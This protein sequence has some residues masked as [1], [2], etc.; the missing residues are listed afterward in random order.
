MCNALEKSH[1]IYHI[2]IRRNGHLSYFHCGIRVRFQLIFLSLIFWVYFVFFLNIL[3]SQLQNVSVN[4]L[5]CLL[6]ALLSIYSQIYFLQCTFI[7]SDK[8]LAA[9]SLLYEHTKRIGWFFSNKYFEQAKI[10][11]KHLSWGKNGFVHCCNYIMC[12]LKITSH[13]TEFGGNGDHQNKKNKKY[14]QP[15]CIFIDYAIWWNKMR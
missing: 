4:V 11:N 8:H 5:N 1:S 14:V 7:V 13:V 12:L 15:C 3:T 2:P 6:N 9:K 10:L